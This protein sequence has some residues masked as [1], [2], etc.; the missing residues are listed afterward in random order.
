MCGWSTG[1]E[2][3]EPPAN[4]DESGSKGVAE[5]KGGETTGEEPVASRLNGASLRSGVECLL[6]WAPW[7]G[8]VWCLCRG[9]ARCW[10]RAEQACGQEEG[11]GEYDGSVGG[12]GG[13]PR[14]GRRR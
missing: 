14:G 7:R 1:E 11:G 5:A 12:G 8:G 13:R 2:R 6:N 3:G 9:G 4:G 10:A